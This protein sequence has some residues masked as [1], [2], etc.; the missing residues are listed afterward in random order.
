MPFHNTVHVI[1]YFTELEAG[2]EMEISDIQKNLS[3]LYE[4]NVMLREKLVA[5]QL[6]LHALE[7]K[8]ASPITESKT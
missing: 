6:L 4:Y 8:S 3:S 7:K 2:S 1:C 5:A